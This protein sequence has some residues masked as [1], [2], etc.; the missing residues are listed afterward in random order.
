M[1]EEIELIKTIA[2]RLESAGI[3]YMMTGSMAQ[4]MYSAP[5]MTRDIDLVVQTYPSDVDT[6]FNLF[7]SQFYIDKES[8]RKAILEHGMFNIIHNESV[9]KVD[10]IVLKDEAYRVEEFARKRRIDL[11]GT[12]IWVVAPE[13]LILSK[14][15]WM[16]QSQSEIQARDVRLLLAHVKTLEMDYL[17]KWSRALGVYDLLEQAQTHG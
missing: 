1:T 8:V 3:E 7:K 4:A 11:E 17:A 10:M 6:L 13:D 14:L 16:K 5:R 2:C 12:L 9:L 15:V